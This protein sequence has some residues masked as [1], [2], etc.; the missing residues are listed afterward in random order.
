MAYF[1]DYELRK[2]DESSILTVNVKVTKEIRFRMWLALK[3]IKLATR[4]LG[5][6]IVVKKEF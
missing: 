1:T 2:L 4:I 6:N 5:C 3:L